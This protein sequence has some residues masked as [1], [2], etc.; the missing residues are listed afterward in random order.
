MQLTQLDQTTDNSYQFLIFWCRW[1]LRRTPARSYL[2]V[3]LTPG[4]LSSVPPPRGIW[5]RP[6]RRRRL[7]GGRRWSSGGRLGWSEEV[8]VHAS[9]NAVKWAEEK[10]G[11]EV[12]SRRG[13]GIDSIDERAMAQKEAWVESKM[14]R[15]QVSRIRISDDPHKWWIWDMRLKNLINANATIICLIQI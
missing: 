7:Q 4:D 13:G 8:T 3:S 9:V 10:L 12:K 5:G 6:K 14:R 1:K 15:G 11:K 2:G